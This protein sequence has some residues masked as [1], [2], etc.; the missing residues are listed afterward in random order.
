VPLGDATFNMAGWNSTYT[1]EPIPV[2][3]MREQLD[4]TVERILALE[5]QSVLEIGCGTGLLLLRLAPHCRRYCASDFSAAAV[6]YVSGQIGFSLPQTEL[7]HAAADDFSGIEPGSFDVVVLNSVIQYFPS[8]EYLDRVLKAAMRVVRPGGYIFVG[9]VRS[10]GLSQAFYASVEVAR[11]GPATTREEVRS[12]VGRRKRLEQ[13]LLVRPE[14][15]ERLCSEGVTAAESELQL[16]RGCTANELTRFR[17]D[18]VLQV[19]QRTAPALAFDEIAWEQV[20]SVA[21]LEAMILHRRPAALVVRGVPN[22]RLL[23]PL[24]AAAW[25]D[26]GVGIITL[27]EWREQRNASSEPGVDP[28][29]I[30]SLEE[31]TGYRVHVGW[32]AAGAGA[33]FDVLMR[34]LRPGLTPTA[35]GWQRLELSKNGPLRAYTNRPLSSDASHRLTRTLREYLGQRLPDHMVPAY[36]VLLDALP[37]TPNGKVDRRNL[38]SPTEVPVVPENGFVAPRTHVE[39][40]IARVWQDVLGI[41]TVGVHDNFFDLGGHSLLMVRVHGQVCEALGADL[42]VTDLFR[43]PTISTLA[44]FLGPGAEVRALGP[45]DDRAVKQRNSM[46]RRASNERTYIAPPATF[47]KPVGAEAVD[48]VVTHTA[49]HPAQVARMQEAWKWRTYRGG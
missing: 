16:K 1:G 13:E 19:G 20:G 11:A 33:Q 40:Q 31:T 49:P 8:A 25:L 46:N 32:S 14:F 43:F 28:E 47:E 4:S 29:A 36:I 39:R 23:E 2:T 27:G 42:S 15:F 21:K 26:T 41:E 44:T 17:Y 18:V 3:E 30:W 35:A 12:R 48:Q 38:P 10:L 34:R 22:A 6:R 24:D 45:V 37:L 7:R 5:P 9:D